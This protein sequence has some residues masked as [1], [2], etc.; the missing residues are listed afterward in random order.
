MAFLIVLASPMATYPV[1]SDGLVKV[2]TDYNN[3]DIKDHLIFLTVTLNIGLTLVT[4][5]V[6]LVGVSSP[7]QFLFVLA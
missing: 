1:N 2:S 6:F 3:F 5:L 7:F 4:V